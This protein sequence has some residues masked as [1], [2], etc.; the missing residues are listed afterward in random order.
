[1]FLA[2]GILVNIFETVYL[3]PLAIPGAKLGLSSLVTL[4]MLLFLPWKDIIANVALRTILASI[5]TGTFLTPALI[6]SLI[7]GIGSSIVMLLIFNLF[8][9]RVF[10][11]IGVSVFGGVSHNVIQLFIATYVLA[12][13]AVWIHLPLLLLTGTLTGM[14][15][16]ILAN[17][18]ASRKDLADLLKVASK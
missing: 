1:M 7:A 13:K 8:Y 6:F 16:G 10:S 4:F 3:P 15:N 17:L 5:M 9:S 11:L 12:T 18:I 2:M 14:F